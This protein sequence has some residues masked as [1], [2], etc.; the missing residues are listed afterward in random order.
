M[1]TRRRLIRSSTLARYSGRTDS[2]ATIQNRWVTSGTYSYEG[3]VHLPPGGT[4]PIA[5]DVPVSGEGTI[6]AF[7]D[8]SVST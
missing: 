4:V 3:V 5:I 1:V 6:P 2:S 7:A 8:Q